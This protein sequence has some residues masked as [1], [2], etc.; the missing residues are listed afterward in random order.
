MVIVTFPLVC[1]HAFTANTVTTSSTSSVSA[2]AWEESTGLLSSLIPQASG[3]TASLTD[4][5]AFNSSAGELKLG[6]APVPEDL[7]SEAERVYKDQIAAEQGT[8][9][10]HDTF[11]LR[12]TVPGVVSPAESDLLPMPPSFKTVDVKREVERVR[13]A[14]KRIRLDPSA[15][16][17]VDPNSPQSAVARARALPSISAYTLHDT[18]EG[19]EFLRKSNLR[20]TY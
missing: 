17:S 12:P 15:A 8:V 9:A 1:T 6:P 5:Q 3:A 4:P 14:R 20:P 18:G 16:S 2:S 19:W 7:R 11:N 13:D 10:Q